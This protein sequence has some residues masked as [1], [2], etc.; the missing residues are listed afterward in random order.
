MKGTAMIH[1]TNVLTAVT[2][3]QYIN[4]GVVLDKICVVKH[5]LSIAT[6]CYHSI[7]LE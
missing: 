7:E 3:R 6:H 4:A 2:N 5:A 1:L